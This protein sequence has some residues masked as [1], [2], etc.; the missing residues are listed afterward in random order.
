M[1]NQHEDRLALAEMSVTLA[2]LQMTQ[3]KFRQRYHFMPPV[4]WSNDPNGLIYFKGQYHLFYQFHPY[5][6]EW[7][8]MHWG[9]ATSYDLI[10]WQHQPIALA[11]SEPYDDHPRGGVFSGSAIEYQG[12]MYVFYTAT[13]HDGNGFVQTQCLAKSSDGITFE[14]FANNPIIRDVPSV[15]SNE[16]R[17]PKVWRQGNYWYMV[18][19]TCKDNLGKAVLYRSN[20]LYQW[21]YINVLAESRGE[22]G[23][24]WEC[25]DVFEIG[26]KYAITFSPVKVHD[27]KA[28]Y[29]IGDLNY[30]TGK[31]NISGFGEVDWGFDAYAPQSMLDPKGRRI[32]FNWANS[33]DWMPW[34]KDYQPIQSEGW[35]G[36]MTLPREVSFD[37]VDH[38]LTFKPVD[39][40]VTLRGQTHTYIDLPLQ[41]GEKKRIEAG[42][43]ISYELIVDINLKKSNA[44]SINLYLRADK[45]YQTLVTLDLKA[46]EIYFDRNQA[47]DWSRGICHTVIRDAGKD[48]L[49][50]RIFSD[51]SSLEIY[52]DGSTEDGYKTVLS[53]NIY[54]NQFCNKIYIES[55]G[56]DTIFD[57]IQTYEIV[58]AW[59]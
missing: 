3:T 56:G 47:D 25:P 19:G 17:D 12:E 45:K 37:P 30:R 20:D 2:K 50:V 26:E 33:W 1:Q 53:G 40:L 6:P 35:C 48:T 22:F 21:E 44:S 27:R 24:M 4:F 32:M 23:T 43:G 58:S 9:H 51:T 14:K 7:G 38:L 8:S 29:L 16:F 11:P 42:D 46:S 13:T 52:T 34:F 49:Q 39:E 5:S 41:S 28:S 10:H 57:R 36:G 31:L 15:G 18:L 55:I 54:P 59:D